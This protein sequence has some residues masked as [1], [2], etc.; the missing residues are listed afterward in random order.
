MKIQ[1]ND[2][3]SYA[4]T[5]REYTDEGFL[6][7]PGRVARV[8]I[9]E[10]LAGELG[11]PGN[12]SRIVRVMRPSEEVFN[13]T[14][15]ATYATSDVTVEHPPVMVDASTFKS[16][17]VGVVVDKARVDGDFVVADLIVKDKAAIASIE[18]GK[19]QLS[20][21]YSAVYDDNVPEGA[22]YEFIQRDIKINH[23][24]LVDRAR[25]GHQARLFDKKPEIPSMAIITLDGRQV[26]IADAATAALVS[27]TVDRLTADLT[28]LGADIEVVTADCDSLQE[29][30]TDAKAL[31]TPEAISARVA[32][33]AKV[34]DAAVK[35]AGKDFTCDST[36]ELE[37]QRAALAS[38]RPKIG[39]ADK[40]EIYVQ[41]AFDQAEEA[42]EE[43]EDTDD[44]GNPFAKKEDKEKGSKDSHIQLGKDGSRK[45]VTLGDA[46]IKNI[47]AKSAAWKVTAGES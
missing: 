34:K 38:K 46:R 45:V 36:V 43:E 7:V 29:Q 21:G 40:S 44:A 32:A 15:L 8:G 11:L 22:D 17:S 23:V 10:Y 31:S 30:L 28:A 9:Q 27:V 26:E 47:A 1:I 14:S 19:V 4:V 18:S 20:A 42:A 16:V 41:T 6:K 13:D 33:I 25:A 24:A 39:W 2:R 35:I 3:V 12:P 37:I 5:S